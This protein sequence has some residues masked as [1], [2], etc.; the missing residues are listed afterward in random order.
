MNPRLSLDAVS[1]GTYGILR[2]FLPPPDPPLSAFP[3]GTTLLLLLLR[4]LFRLPSTYLLQLH[5][6]YRPIVVYLSIPT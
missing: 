2:S 1:N 3:R 5:G 4:L 6:N